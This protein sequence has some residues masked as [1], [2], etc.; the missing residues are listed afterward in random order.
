MSLLQKTLEYYSG[1]RTE[2]L[3]Y[4]P[5]DANR[6]LEIG[7]GQGNFARHLL[8]GSRE[9][10]G[11]EPNVQAAQVASSK[12]TKVF[13]CKIEDCIHK[14]PDNYFDVIIFN[15]VLEHLLDPWGIL[16]MMRSKLSEDGEIVASLPN[17]RYVKNLF[18]IFIRKDWVYEE[19][20]ILDATHV[21][22]FTR[23]S[24]IRLFT[25]S[26]YQI[27]R[28]DGLCRTTSI[29]GF[30]LALILNIVSFGYHDDVFFK[31]YVIIAKRRVI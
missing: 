20:G 28:I 11:V 23:K 4:V 6:I 5:E 21:R 7:C 31:Q 26:K 22:F 18:N 2:I 19:A 24:M 12:L 17:L 8:R 15:D 16:E 25:K 3:S 27:L 30:I 13:S 9:V 10:W 14:V 1:D 29:K